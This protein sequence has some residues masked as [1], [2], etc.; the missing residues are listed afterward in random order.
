[1]IT[2]KHVCD[3]GNHFTFEFEGREYVMQRD[4][5]ERVSSEEDRIVFAKESIKREF[6]AALSEKDFDT[7]A[8]A[9]VKPV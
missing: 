7:V 1:M 8:R 4:E 5:L 6:K 3:G 2:L 9:G